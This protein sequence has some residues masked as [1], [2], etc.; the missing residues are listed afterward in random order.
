MDDRR[1]GLGEREAPR[2]RWARRWH[3]QAGLAVLLAVLVVS[4]QPAAAS[5]ATAKPTGV[6]GR[7]ASVARSIVTPAPSAD[8]ATVAAVRDTVAPVADSRP[9]FQVAFTHVDDAQ[10]GR[11][12]SYT[13]EV[14]NAG[15]ASGAV[16]VSTVLPPEL[17]NVRVTAPGFVCTRRFSA[18]GT[19][20]GTLVT[21]ARNDLGSGEAADI[22]VEANAPATL[23]AVHLTAAA[24]ARDDAP[25]GDETNNSAD[26]VVQIQG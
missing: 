6:A 14:R 18:S 21:C 19:Q 12:F 8:A 17:A 2:E 24:S 9:D 26:A 22:T 10:A 11:P 23:G 16:T 15:A 25:D 3:R 1:Y 4:G 7:V 5:Y 13:L 20:V